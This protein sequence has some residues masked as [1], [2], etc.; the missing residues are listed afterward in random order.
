MVNSQEPLKQVWYLLEERN[1]LCCQLLCHLESL[2]VQH[3]LRNDLTVRL[4]H[5]QGS[6]ELLEV[7]RQVGAARIAR[8]HGDE[9]ASVLAYFHLP[10][11][12]V[13]HNGLGVATCSEGA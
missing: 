13:N 1:S 11:Y 12:Q 3:D 10:A 2:R 8:V 4:C 7:V 9:D 5:G 6:E